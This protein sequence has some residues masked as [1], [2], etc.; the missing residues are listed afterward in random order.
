MS[1]E[2]RIN[3]SEMTTWMRCPRKWD[4]GY[5]QGLRPLTESTKLSL[6]TLVHEALRVH[7]QGGDAME[8]LELAEVQSLSEA[9]EEMLQDVAKETELAHLMMEGYLEWLS[10]TGADVGLEFLL[11]EEE[12][13]VPFGVF[14]GPGNAWSVDITLH[15]RPDLLIRDPEVGLT[16]VD[17][18]TVA[19]FGALA[20]RRLQ[21]NFQGLT[22]AWMWWKLTGERPSGLTLNML[23]KVKRTAA[24]KPPFYARETVLFNE[25]QLVAHEG[26]M[27][28]IVDDILRSEYV[29]RRDHPVP[30]SDCT[31]KCEFLTPCT[32]L[33]EHP[34]GAQELLNELY[35]RR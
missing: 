5:H 24:A 23:R 10:E 25:A 3:Q 27:R 2:R 22:Y 18:K 6:G 34:A 13:Q 32:M 33:D 9:P 35:T 4:L 8:Y 17:H 30:D 1:T 11:C 29:D 20:D 28:A 19:A 31:W 21:M 16:V 7:Y 15:G 12:L 14:T 26:H